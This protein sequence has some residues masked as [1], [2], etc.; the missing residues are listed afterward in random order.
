[1]LSAATSLCA[2]KPSYH[3]AALLIA[4]RQNLFLRVRRVH[5]DKIRC[6]LSTQ[7]TVSVS[8]PS[9]VA[10][11]EWWHTTW[12]AALS[13][14]SHCLLL[15]AVVW[16]WSFNAGSLSVD[17]LQCFTAVWCK[18]C[19]SLHSNTKPKNILPA[20][21]WKNSFIWILTETCINCIVQSPKNWCFSSL[22]HADLY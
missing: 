18:N 22:S 5:G 17:M 11:F 13:V 2:T 12:T 1:M 9:E 21:F 16:T 8:V 10:L 14:V 19:V 20:C 7:T 4:L 3:R 15:C 6:I